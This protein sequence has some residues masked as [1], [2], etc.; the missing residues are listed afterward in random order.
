[1]PK[2]RAVDLPIMTLKGSLMLPTN[3][4]SAGSA[5]LLS[6]FF[7]ISYLPEPPCHS[8]LPG[9]VRSDAGLRNTS[10]GLCFLGASGVTALLRLLGR[11]VLFLPFTRA[12]L[13]VCS[14]SVAALY[15]LLVGGLSDGK[16]MS[17]PLERDRESLSFCF[18][19]RAARLR[20]SSASGPKTSPL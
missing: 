12:G 15:S 5:V 8:E 6:D 11:G 17:L 16:L 18:F 14:Y 9:L 3:S 2:E 13:L 1:M 20:F 4:D 19:W 7:S 10:R